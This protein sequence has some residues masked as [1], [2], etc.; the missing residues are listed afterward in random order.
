MK[1]AM[2]KARK[3]PVGK[4]R[5]LNLTVSFIGGTSYQRSMVKKHAPDWQQGTGVRFIFQ[6]KPGK[7]RVAFE[8]SGSSWSKIGTDALTVTNK[9]HPTMNFSWINQRVILHEFGHA[10]GLQHEHSSPSAAIPWDK[11]KV[12]RYYHKFSGW[13]RARVDGNILNR[14][15]K[16]TTNYTRFDPNSIMLYSIRSDLLKPNSGWR[17][18]TC[19]TVLS[20]EDRIFMAKMYPRPRS[21]R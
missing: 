5:Y 7:I 13:S 15:N 1:A 8:N 20:S 12:Y 4:G 6:Q 14:Y 3:W 21:T 18:I 2:S 16:A 10:L 19:K 11:E 9:K 17:G